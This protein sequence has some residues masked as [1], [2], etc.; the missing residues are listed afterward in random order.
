M[1]KEFIQIL[2]TGNN[3]WV[4]ISTIGAEPSEAFIYDSKYVYLFMIAYFPVP[5]D[6]SKRKLAAL[7]Y[8]NKS[9]MTLKFV[10]VALQTNGSDCSIYAITFATALCLGQS[11]CLLH[12]DESRMRSHLEKCL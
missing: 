11:P 1:A 2:H 7:L 9:S 6:S 4:T 8:E 12:F 5:Q 10:K 3:H